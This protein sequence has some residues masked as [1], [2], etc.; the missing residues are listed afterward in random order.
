MHDEIA[1]IYE[2]KLKHTFRRTENRKVYF[3]NTQFRKIS[4]NIYSRWIITEKMQEKLKKPN[5][6]YE[7]PTNS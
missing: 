5:N 7:K 6:I 4:C 3:L 2:K 1:D